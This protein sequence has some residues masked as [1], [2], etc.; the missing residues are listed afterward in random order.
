MDKTY[1]A[2]VVG[3]IT[4]ASDVATFDLRGSPKANRPTHFQLICM[5]GLFRETD[6]R[7][8]LFQLICLVGLFRD[9][10][11]V[12]DSLGCWLFNG[13]DLFL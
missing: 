12:A 3:L 13:F 2:D 8:I 10:L 6:G 1:L 4:E 5:V 11:S 7:S 9:C